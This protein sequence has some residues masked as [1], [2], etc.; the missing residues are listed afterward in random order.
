MSVNQE[1]AENWGYLPE[2]DE[3]PRAQLIKMAFTDELTGLANR[4]AAVMHYNRLIS[5]GKTVGALSIDITNFKNVNDEFSYEEG[6]ET[7]QKVGSFLHKQIVTLLKDQFRLGEESIDE[8]DHDENEPNGVFK[9]F[10]GRIGGD[11]FLALI[12][13]SDKRDGNKTNDLENMKK[14]AVR[15]GS[16][17][18]HEDFIIE[19]NNRPEI[20]E[21]KKLGLWAAYAVAR[22]TD[23]LKALH[24][25]ASI[26]KVRSI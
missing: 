25:K 4:H 16:A 18:N 11:E 7:L 21:D 3:I 17:L 9:D 15:V 5:N 26:K 2:M 23:T 14:I 22:R 8:A 24:A 1:I 6:D 20:T 13:L 12:N 19:Y 10:L